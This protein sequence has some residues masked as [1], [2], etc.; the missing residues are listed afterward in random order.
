MK[1]LLIL[2]L[3]VFMILSNGISVFAQEKSIE[4]VG[5]KNQVDNASNSFT[6]IYNE[7]EA[8][9]FYGK[10]GFD[11]ITEEE[12]THFD[13][14]Y[15]VV[16]AIAINDVN[17]D[18]YTDFL[19]YLNSAEYTDEL[20]V[21]SGQDGSVISSRRI[22]RDSYSEENGVFKAN[23][24]VLKMSEFN[25]LAVVLYDYTIEVID[26]K[27]AEVIYSY[28]NEDNIWDYE[29]V[30]NKLVFIDQLGCI[31]VCD[32]EQNL[33]LSYYKVTNNYEV[34]FQWRPELVAP[35]K[36]NLWDIE[37]VCGQLFIT[38]EDG[39][40]LT[41][42]PETFLVESTVDLELF[43]EDE[44]KGYLSDNL[45]YVTDSEV[46]QRVT[47][48][49]SPYF[50]S[51][52]ILDSN[53]QYL[54]I[55]GFIKDNDCLSD[56]FWSNYGSSVLVYDYINQEVVS[57][58]TL[59][60]D[61]SN[62]DATLSKYDASETVTVI[63]P[64][65]GSSL[66]TMIYDFEGSVLLQKEIKVDTI[67][68]K[69]RLSI[70][71][72][73]ENG[74]YVQAFNNSCFTLN[75][76]L[77][78]AIFQ[79]EKIS[80]QSVYSS[81][82]GFTMMYKVNGIANKIVNYGVDGST[83]NW[84][85]ELTTTE[86]NK[87]IEFIT[88]DDYNKDGV[89]DY[90]CIVNKYDSKDNVVASNFIVIN[91]EDG[92]QLFSK[93]VWLY[94][95]Y[96]A[97]W[98]PYDVYLTASELYLVNDI[99]G[100]G[101]KEFIIDGNIVT[102]YAFA[103]KGTV[104][105]YVDAK[106]VMQK[107][108]DVNGDGFEDFVMIEKSTVTQ[109]VS[110]RNR[111]D[112]SY[113]KSG[114]VFKASGKNTID[115]QTYAVIFNDID[116]DG[117]KEI[118]FND[119]ND[120]G[121]QYFRVL[122]GKSLSQMYT[123][124]DKGVS[125]YELL[126]L[127]NIDITGDGINELMY[128]TGAMWMPTI[129]DGATGEFLIAIDENQKES[130]YFDPEDYYHPDWPVQIM[131]EDDYYSN[132]PICVINDLDGDEKPDFI[133]KKSYYDYE[134]WN[135]YDS[136]LYYS[137][138]TFEIVDEKI[139]SVNKYE[140]MGSLKPVVN[141]DKYIVFIKNE[142]SELM[143]SVSG[144]VIANYDIVAES[145]LLLNENTILANNKESGLI[146]LDI[147][148]AFELL[149]EIPETMEGHILELKWKPAQDYSVMKIYDNGTL[150]TTTSDTEYSLPLLGGNHSIKL[151]LADGQ[152]KESVSVYNVVVETHPITDYYVIAIAVVLLAGSLFSNMYRKAYIK[153][154][155]KG[156]LQ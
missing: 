119:I 132:L 89:K 40:L 150:V 114:K 96:D 154:K 87:G 99:D 39:Y 31:G 2:L 125:D 88:V 105:T 47:G 152:G 52:R 108:G 13:T 138:A 111:Y 129:R 115:N 19:A 79:F 121:Y 59:K 26:P 49:F 41:Y 116:N 27:T 120:A 29:V 112:V 85:Y 20:F 141:S 102:S 146:T 53:E 32:L 151:Q 83:E 61:G 1:K 73:E 7:A 136:L 126:T 135:R 43:S 122:N 144:Q 64:E 11:I 90:I 46:E 23:T 93:K 100:D 25:G 51:I 106:G 50:K 128:M 110:R 92:K 10:N 5:V 54:L 67:N 4:Y 48:L 109:Y 76:S 113:V 6:V 62:V 37:N 107:I 104:N 149:S 14:K 60:T 21:F 77:E 34:S 84:V 65:T 103:A 70:D 143:D 8:T 12:K 78:D 68:N 140:E 56:Y 66:R 156:G 55:S 72:D 82:D 134:T 58:I 3:T 148:N 18:G 74:Y 38:T 24:E 80:T 15:P 95:A 16:K 139:L 127:M 147:R 28:V 44:L 123:L 63:Y 22:T 101:K 69:T 137:S 94:K 98:R 33:L 155:S 130:T 86:K 75:A 97:N 36:L 17:G 81:E 117:V 131:T 91:G 153:K 42:N 35:S 9:V 145:F 57:E 118:V 133:I 71:F 142:K 30:D 124:A 45:S